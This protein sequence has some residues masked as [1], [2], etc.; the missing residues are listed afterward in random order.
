MD[1]HGA[2]DD[3]VGIGPGRL[4]GRGALVTATTTR[5][6]NATGAAATRGAN[7]AGAAAAAGATRCTTARTGATCPMAASALRRPHRGRQRRRWS[8]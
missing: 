8:I 4:G 3:G 7:A 5:G 2:L 6:A 1:N